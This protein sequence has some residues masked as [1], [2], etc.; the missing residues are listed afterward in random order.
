MKRNLLVASSYS[1]YYQPPPQPITSFNRKK[2]YSSLI[3][4]NDIFKSKESVG[5]GWGG[6]WRRKALHCTREETTT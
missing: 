4:M 2:R 6:E 5:K 3:K 1:G